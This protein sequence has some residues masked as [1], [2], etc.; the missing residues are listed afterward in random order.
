MSRCI[1]M[2]ACERDGQ[3]TVEA[4]LALP[5]FLL[6]LL[7]ALQPA[8]LLYTRA[9]M[10][11]AATQT[12]RLMVTSSDRDAA[13]YHAFALRRL[14]AVPDVAIFHEGGPLSW[15]I[16]CT[17]AQGSGGETV[18]TIEGTVSPLPVIGAFAH[19]FGETNGMGDV[20]LHVEVRLGG[21]PAWLK[22]NYETWIA[23][24]N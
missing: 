5:A 17:G 2:L 15:E 10:E 13:G 6:L 24:W 21:R 22:G 23:R 7:L 3:A 11:V 8:C 20:V 12:A 16:A 4:A 9:V 14:A 19:A 1:E 18:V